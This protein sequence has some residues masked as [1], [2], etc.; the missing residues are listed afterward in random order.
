MHRFKLILLFAAIAF[1]C[2][3]YRPEAEL[4]SAG[5]QT[6]TA[7][8]NF[9]RDIRPLLHARCIEC[10]GPEKQKSG[11]RLD[12]KADAMKGGASGPVIVAGRSSE[13]ELIRRVT[14][15]DISEMMPPAG[16]RLTA[17]KVALLRAWIDD[18]AVWPVVE[19]TSSGEAMRADKATWWSLQP[20]A[21]VEPPRTKGIPPE[22]DESPID[23]FV[24]AKLAENGLKPNP[25]ADRRTLIRRVSYDLTGLPP[26]P[27]EVEAF[28]ADPDPQAYRKLVDRLL[29]SP[30]YGEQWGRHWLDVARFG[31][32]KGFEQNHIINNLW[33]YR[34]YVIRSFNEDKPFNRF[35]VEQLAGD[36]VGAG[37]P[38]VETG[39]AFLVCGPYDAVG[40]QDKTQQLVI[41]ANTIDDLITAASNAFLLRPARP[42]RTR[43][44]PPRCLP[45]ERA[46]F[47]DRRPDRFRPARQRIVC[48]EPHQHDVAAAGADL[49]QPRIH[50]RHGWRAGGA[51]QTRSP[52]WRAEADMARV[53]S[54]LPEAAVAGRRAGRAETDRC[55]RLERVLPRAAQRQRDALPELR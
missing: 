9:E 34:D 6:Q 11:L 20:L 15:A 16:E 35:V 43:N 26:S 18:G 4:A 55:A 42:A 46:R 37:D 33:P 13:S 53:R 47:G 51:R 17:R 1:S 25:A 7:A 41:R 32:S 50:A 22:W 38:S 39:T 21:R 36:V 54:C 3:A 29:D 19:R 8:V 31:E 45:P 49:A 28:V 23:R 12:N 30:R 52:G 27:E 48:A 2:F 14:S 24:Y 5:Y 10:H 40:N 44:L